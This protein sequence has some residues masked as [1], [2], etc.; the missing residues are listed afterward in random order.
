V[1]RKGARVGG[2]MLS[3]Y[4][5][6]F[7][8]LT[9]R[10]T[11]LAPGER[12]SAPIV[13][14]D[15]RLARQALSYVAGLVEELRMEVRSRGADGV[16]LVRPDGRD[17]TIECLPATA[18]GRAVRGRSLVAALFTEA[19]FFK[20]EN[21]SVNDQELYRAVMPRVMPG[22]Q[23]VIESTPFAELGLLYS[24]DNENF[25][26]PMSAIVAH[27]ATPLMRPELAS[28]V[29]SERKRDP[30]N[31]SREFDGEYMSAGSGLFF[32]PAAIDAAVDEGL[33]LGA[34]AVGSCAAGMD[35]AF[36]SDSSAL[37]V[38]ATTRGEAG[39]AN[40]RLVALKEL[41]PEK[42]KPLRTDE[43]IETFSDIAESYRC[44]N[45]GADAHYRQV[46]V[47]HLQRSGLY[48]TDL[49]GGQGGKAS[50]YLLTREL[51]YAG[52]LKLPNHERLLN[53]MKAI[54]S[55][56]QPGGGLQISSP[57]RGRSTGHG[58]LVSALTAAV[59]MA[60]GKGAL[61]DYAGAMRG[62]R[63]GAF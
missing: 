29:E 61:V 43:V 63:P 8:A 18:G 58:D 2:T 7:L 15:M 4:R 41:Q 55:R 19:A 32:D 48:L 31:A 17:V 24:L 45:I 36:Q 40:V 3:A 9:V 50:V 57:R 10:L 39:E 14:P 46:A 23:L 12:A 56:P 34:P 6:L 28:F 53:Q 20:D 11:G 1:L 22:G 47:E 42:G 60:A 44:S 54:V 27:A 30:Q 59:H 52:R 51:L 38:V 25:G 21:Y 49:P 33:E 37:A 13:A 16:T 26:A 5:L 35:L 62:L